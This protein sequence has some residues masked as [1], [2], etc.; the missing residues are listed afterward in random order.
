MTRAERFAG[1]L[2]VPFAAED[3]IGYGGEVG[4]AFANV[5]EQVGVVDA[6]AAR[7]KDCQR[8][9]AL[10]FVAD[11]RV[12]AGGWVVIHAGSRDEEPCEFDLLEPAGCTLNAPERLRE[13]GDPVSG[14]C[15][16]AGAGKHRRTQTGES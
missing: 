6:Q 10:V 14:R 12:A 9:V 11:D 13:V 3:V 4:I 16:R 8:G 2:P 15:S 7:G 1:E 5:F